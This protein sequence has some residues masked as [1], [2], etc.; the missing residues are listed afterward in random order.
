[1]VLT[2]L[3][4]R[5][6]ASTLR[7][8]NNFNSADLSPALIRYLLTLS[9]SGTFTASSQLDRLNSKAANNEVSYSRT[10]VVGCGVRAVRGIGRLHSEGSATSGYHLPVA[11]H[12]HRICS[13]FKKKGPLPLSRQDNTHGIGLLRPTV[14]PAAITCRSSRTGGL[15]ICSGAS[16]TPT[17]P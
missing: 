10:A 7:R 11:V 15:A 4:Q 8:D 14:G 3:S 5:R 12:P 17:G 16:R 9:R 13:L 6:S 2:G 1:M